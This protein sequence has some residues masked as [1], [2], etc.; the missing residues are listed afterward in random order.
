ME[1]IMRKVAAIIT[2]FVLV[3]FTL[4]VAQEEQ[5]KLLLKHFYLSLEKGDYQQASRY[6]TSKGKNKIKDWKA[7]AD[8][9]IAPKDKK[10][11]K[12]LEADKSDSYKGPKGEDVWYILITKMGKTFI[13]PYFF[14]MQK[15]KGELKMNIYHL[16]ESK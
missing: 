13:L 11:Q 8:D 12:F 15:E 10:E 4:A 14:I 2:I 3:Y 5:P 1:K 16:T 7:F 9:I 6:L